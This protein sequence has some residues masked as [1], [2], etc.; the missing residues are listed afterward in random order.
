MS[1]A[2]AEPGTG[3]K[4]TSA[5]SS[6][7][8]KPVYRRVLLKLSGEALMGGNQFGIDPGTLH[9]MAA[10]VQNVHQMGVDVAGQGVQGVCQQ[11]VGVGYRQGPQRKP[12]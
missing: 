5:E 10:E 1:A 4:N 6:T 11:L 2:D 7:L 9:R 3:S 12:R 8:P